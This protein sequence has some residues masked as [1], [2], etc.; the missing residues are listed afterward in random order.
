MDSA[1]RTGVAMIRF[2]FKVLRHMVGLL[3]AAAL[4]FLV[5]TDP[6]TTNFTAFHAF[7]Q[8]ANV[9]AIA[10]TLAVLFTLLP[11]L[12]GENQPHQCTAKGSG[13]C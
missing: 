3:M 13:S 1:I 12:V 8:N 5:F 10:A 9:L 4:L 7:F 11:A 2:S 6:A